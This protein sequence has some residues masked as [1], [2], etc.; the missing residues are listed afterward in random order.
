MVEEWPIQWPCCTDEVSPEVIEMARQGAQDLLW[1]LSGRRLGITNY[2][3]SYYPACRCGC[4]GPYK[5]IQG[6]WRNGSYSYDCCR[7]LLAHRPVVDVTEVLVFGQVL[8]SEEY[9]WSPSYLRSR[10]SCWPCLERCLDPPIEVSY[11]AGVPLPGGTALAMGEVACEILSGLRGDPCQLPSRAVSVS[12]QG[13]TVDLGEPALPG[14]LG[15]PLT[16]AWLTMVNPGRLDRPSR[17]YSVDL[18]ARA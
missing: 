11:T 3:E 15:L 2:H 18:P 9:G 8:A 1:A 7:L 17:V 12:R 14:R 13:V 10:W 16:D 6:Y 4:I 5:T